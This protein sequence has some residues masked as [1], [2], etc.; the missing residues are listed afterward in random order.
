MFIAL[1]TVGNPLPDRLAFIKISRTLQR[2]VDPI[3]FPVTVGFVSN[4][5]PFG[6]HRPAV[7]MILD[8]KAVNNLRLLLLDAV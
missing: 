8:R 3:P 5:F 4:H 2:A 6:P 1:V 7:R